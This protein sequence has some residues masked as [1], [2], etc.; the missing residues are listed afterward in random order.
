M[1]TPHQLP[2]TS[3]APEANSQNHVSPS[4]ATLE[5]TFGFDSLSA[6]LRF[7]SLDEICAE[8]SYRSIP[9]GEYDKVIDPAAK[10]D[11][12]FDI[13]DAF[14][15]NAKMMEFTANILASI[16]RLFADRD[17]NNPSYR[18]SFYSNR[19][20]FSGQALKPMPQSTRAIGEGCFT[21]TGPSLMGRSAL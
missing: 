16:R 12:L 19:Q 10:L 2:V 8:L 3:P 13:K 9:Y 18:V 20:V 5:R 1:N 17:F 4:G 6:L 7:R 21:V 11:V 14:L 15:P